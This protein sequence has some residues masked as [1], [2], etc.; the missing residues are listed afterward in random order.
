MDIHT[1]TCISIVSSLHMNVQVTN[2]QRFR[3]AFGCKI[4]GVSSHVWRP[5]VMCVNPQEVID[6][7]FVCF[8]T[9]SLFQA[10]DFQ[11]Q[12]LKQ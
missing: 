8:I 5:F 9:V 2:F 4:T 10:L 3:Y 6:C 7:T 11:K 12:A 1:Q